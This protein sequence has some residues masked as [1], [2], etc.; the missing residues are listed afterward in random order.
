MSSC[1]PE[2]MIFFFLIFFKAFSFY[3]LFSMIQIFKKFSRCLPQKENYIKVHNSVVCLR[4]H[5]C[6]QLLS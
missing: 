3:F 1:F 5:Y 2:V 6:V 4:V